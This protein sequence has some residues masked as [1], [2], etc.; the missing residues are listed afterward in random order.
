MD[1]FYAATVIRFNA[2]CSVGCDWLDRRIWAGGVR[3]ITNLVLVV[4]WASR[5][6]DEYVVNLGFDAGCGRIRRSSGFMSRLQDGQVQNYLRV[7]GLALALLV[8][9]LTWGWMAP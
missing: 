8:L 4:S 9:F 1:E 3:L 5:I 7:I 6:F 2:G